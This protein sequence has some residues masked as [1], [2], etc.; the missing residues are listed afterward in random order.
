MRSGLWDMTTRTRTATLPAGASTVA[1]SADGILAAADGDQITLWDMATLAS[2]AVVRH[3][4]GSGWGP[5]INAVAFSPDGSILASGSDDATVR[6]WHASTGGKRERPWGTRSACQAR[7]S[8]RP[9]G[10]CSL[11]GGAWGMSS[12]GTLGQGAAWPPSGR[13]P[14]APMP[15]PFPPDGRVLAAGSDAAIELWDMAEWLQP[16][17]KRLVVISGDT[18]G[19]P[20]RRPVG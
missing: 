14:R 3:T 18:P 2:T 4:G 10:P 5:D 13:R 11:P 15:S 19:G 17:P 16:R 6:L 1:V 7:W 20:G 12:S 9:T 8:S